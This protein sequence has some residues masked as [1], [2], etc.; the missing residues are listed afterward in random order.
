MLCIRPSAKTSEY[1][2]KVESKGI[3]KISRIVS[4]YFLQ[5]FKE[6]ENKVY[7][8]LSEWK[9]D[10]LEEKFKG[11]EICRLWIYMYSIVP[12]LIII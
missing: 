3:L 2:N 6:M 1:E 5:S 9:L 7:K 8:V 11:K 10:K 12:L 4:D